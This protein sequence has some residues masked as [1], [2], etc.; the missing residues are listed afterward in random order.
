MDPIAM[1]A[2][3]A[4]PATETKLTSAGANFK[5]GGV[6]E[7]LMSREIGMISGEAKGLAKKNAGAGDPMMWLMSVLMQ[8]SQASGAEQTEA[9]Q[10]DGMTQAVAGVQPEEPQPGED[11]N[12]VLAEAAAALLQW[13]TANPEQVQTFVNDLKTG[14]AGATQV[15]D[16]ISDALQGGKPQPGWQ[17]ADIS[18]LLQSVVAG[19]EQ[20]AAAGN[21][22]TI[23]GNRALKQIKELFAQALTAHP[24]ETEHTPV[25]STAGVWAQEINSDTGLQAT[26]PAEAPQ[27]A[28]ASGTQTVPANAAGKASESHG[29]AGANAGGGTQTSGDDETVTFHA[30]L[31]AYHSIVQAPSQSAESLPAKAVATATRPGTEAF[32]AIVQGIS[33]L[34]DASAKEIQIELKP[35]F[36]GKVTIHLAMEE[37]GLVAK[38]AAANPRVQDSFLNQVNSLQSV[39]ADQGLKDVRVI[40]T[41]SSVQDLNLQQQADRRSQNQQ[42]QQKRNRFAVQGVETTTTPAVQAYEAFYNTSAINYLA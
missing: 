16:S 5:A 41:S 30:A 3:A 14:S 13:F 2:Q 37:G 27:A 32:D 22:E 9:A 4:Q 1:V 18:A 8:M 34:K 26:K 40:V 36:L 6:F 7:I 20:Q 28:V 15:A 19:D 11:K 35:E 39:L 10:A 17:A 29:S 38:I 25:Q 42:Q 24:A 12:T 23:E 31:R 21:V 33:G